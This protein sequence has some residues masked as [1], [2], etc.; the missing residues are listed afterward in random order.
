MTD[1]P[2]SCSAVAGC[3]PT[4]RSAFTGTRPQWI[5]KKAK[6]QTNQADANHGRHLDA[7]TG[8]ETALWESFGGPNW[9]CSDADF[10]EPGCHLKAPSNY[11]WERE[12][13]THRRT[14]LVQRKQSLKYKV[15][16]YVQFNNKNHI[17]ANKQKSCYK[18]HSR[19]PVKSLCLA[20]K[21]LPILSFPLST[22]ISDVNQACGAIACHICMK[23]V[24]TH[25]GSTFGSR[26]Y[27]WTLQA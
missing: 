12:T 13:R 22:H 3:S 17:H 24:T 25:P 20:K 1:K 7:T 2:R 15:T 26:W 16:N 27:A 9:I 10:K 5:M 4:Y 18:L 19:R 11:Y 14:S 21:A 8:T 23:V 6:A